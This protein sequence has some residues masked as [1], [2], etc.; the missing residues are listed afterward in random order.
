MVTSAAPG[1]HMSIL[2]ITI[3]KALDSTP[4]ISKVSMQSIQ[5]RLGTIVRDG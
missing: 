5:E 2:R 3:R 1:M 4:L